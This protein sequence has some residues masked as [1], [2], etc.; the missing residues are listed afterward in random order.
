MPPLSAAG[1]SPGAL[2][3]PSLGS[4]R[5]GAWS[6]QRSGLRPAARLDRRRGSGRQLAQQSPP[7]VAP[8]WSPPEFAQLRSPPEFAPLRS[9][10]ELAQLR[11]PPEL[12]PLRSLPELAP[13]RSPAELAQLRSSPE[14]AQL[15]SSPEFGR[16]LEPRR[17][18]AGLSLPVL[19]L[20]AFLCCFASSPALPRTRRLDAKHNLWCVPCCR[21]HELF[22]IFLLCVVPSRLSRP[23]CPRSEPVCFNVVNDGSQ[24]GNEL[25]FQGYCLHPRRG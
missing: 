18:P 13:L 4:S 3:H 17:C 16:W 14:F 8:L 24:T 7:E 10:P 1:S 19:P 21:H 12:A 9:P 23:R 22:A 5:L 6:S 11:S 2:P 20:V 25:A 15:R